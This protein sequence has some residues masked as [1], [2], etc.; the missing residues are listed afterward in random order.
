[1]RTLA[2]HSL[3][4]H[5]YGNHSRTFRGANRFAYGKIISTGKELVNFHRGWSI[6]TEYG[7]GSALK[8]KA[9]KVEKCMQTQ[10]R[11]GKRA[12]DPFRGLRAGPVRFS[13]HFF[14]G[15]QPV[16]FFEVLPAVSHANRTC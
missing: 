3:T 8:E 15:S 4:L 6:F 12:E 11:W 10:D 1:M 13:P 7:L 5:P 14:D 16:R 9:L 2:R